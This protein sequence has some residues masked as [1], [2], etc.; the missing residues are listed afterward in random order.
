M[1]HVQYNDSGIYVCRAVNSYGTQDRATQLFI[2]GLEAPVIGNIPPEM[3][4]LEGDDVRIDCI[5]VLGIPPPERIWYKNNKPIYE[6]MDKR[7]IHID[8]DG[9]LVIKNFGPDDESTYSCVAKNVVSTATQKSRVVL[10]SRP[11]IEA[12]SL[13]GDIGVAPG[14]NLILPCPATGTPK[15]KVAW[16]LN[17]HI[18][19][20]QSKDYKILPDNSL[21]ITNVGKQHTGNFTCK[22]VNAAGESSFDTRVSVRT[23]PTISPSQVSFNHVLGDSVVLPC[24]VEGEPWPDIK[25]YLNGEP[26]PGEVDKNDGSLIMDDI[27]LNHRGEYKC[28][29][30]NDV[31][32][33]EISMNLTVHTI[34]IIDG[35]G[36][37]NTFTVTMNETAVLPCPA[38]ATPPP[39]RTWLYERER[40]ELSPETKNI[41]EMAPNGSLLLK[42]VK[43]EHEGFYTCH[44]SNLAGED[45]IIYSLKVQNPPRI[46]SRLAD[47]VDVVLGVDLELP[48][49]ALGTPK[50]E[51]SW[52]KDGFQVIPNNHIHIDASGSLK[53]PKVTLNDEGHFTC[54]AKNPAGEDV[55]SINVVVQEP[56]QPPQVSQNQLDEVTYLQGEEAILRC[57]VRASP[58]PI[59]RWFRGDSEIEPS[60]DR[61]KIRP[62]GSLIISSAAKDDNLIYRCRA[63]NTAGFVEVPIRLN[64]IVPPEITDSDVVSLESVKVNEPF[65]LYCPVVSVP[66]PH[67]SWRMNEKPIV[68]DSTNIIFSEDK[69]RLRVSQSR[70]TDAGIYKCI[71]RNP[72]GESSKSFEVEVLIPP[73]KNET[74]Y[75]TKQTALEHQRV[76]FGCPVSGIPYPTIVEWYVNMVPLKPGETKGGVSFYM[77]CTK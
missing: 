69:R 71:A 14:E 60:T 62:D 59:F 5:L 4:V 51:V 2:V 50:P 42:N 55:R 20:V 6:T 1:W 18:L 43:T 72:A 12:A 22:A 63:E 9:A 46:V 40:I 75:S 70:V 28:T 41:A 73:Q 39:E 23:P 65:S 33:D 21:Q 67:I 38:R 19:D 47:T 26:A 31:G 57:D 64:V 66:L 3:Q 27:S 37:P 29:A 61:H 77:C 36:F 53:I 35:S 56:P 52:Q 49:R 74:I 11:R 68:E 58:N 8:G 24:E 16:L 7:R 30:K 76:E 25:W 54:V 13:K 34:P 32:T 17:S 48:C 44:V 45:E 15:P 10:I